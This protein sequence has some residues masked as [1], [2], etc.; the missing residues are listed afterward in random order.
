[1]ACRDGAR[2][3][4]LGAFE[5]LFNCVAPVPVCGCRIARAIHVI[6]GLFLPSIS[7]VCCCL[8]AWFFLRVDSRDSRAI[9]FFQ[10][11]K[12][13][14]TPFWGSLG[15]PG[16]A[17]L[18]MVGRAALVRP[19][20]SSLRQPGPRASPRFSGASAARVG[21]NRAG[22]PQSIKNTTAVRTHRGISGA[23]LR[24]CV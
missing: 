21:R 8:V 20:S 12:L 18:T 2:A 4:R 17:E 24:S 22:N 6:L 16:H 7:F 11:V 5:D 3:G 23:S 10:I 15:A 13:D 14:L 19:G 1:M 9:G